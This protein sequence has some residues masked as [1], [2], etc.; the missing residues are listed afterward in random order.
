MA[1]VPNSSVASCIPARVPGTPAAS[2]PLSFTRPGGDPSGAVSNMSGRAAAGAVE[3]K[4]MTLTGLFAMAM[5][6]CPPYPPGPH[7]AISTTPATRAAATIPS[8]T[9]PPSS[10]IR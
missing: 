1:R 2:H 7:A 5:V 8:T 4:S 6:M 10:M 9:F 3:L